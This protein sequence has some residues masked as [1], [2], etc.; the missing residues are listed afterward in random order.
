MTPTE[1]PQPNHIGKATQTL[2]TPQ[3]NVFEYC[4]DDYPSTLECAKCDVTDELTTAA[5]NI[6][7]WYSQEYY[8]NY[9]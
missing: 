9:N 8:S 7:D 6:E 3:G 4:I 2:V 1:Q 5:K